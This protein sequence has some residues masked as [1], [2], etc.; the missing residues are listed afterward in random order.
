MNSFI[1]KS[2]NSPSINFMFIIF[3]K[4]RNIYIFLIF[5]SIIFLYQLSSAQNQEII[6]EVEKYLNQIKTAK[7]QFKQIGPEK[8]M[9]R[10][11]FFYIAKPGKLKW[12]Y[13][14]PKKIT[15]ISD[16]NKV[17][18]YDHEMEELT[19]IDQDHT[20]AKLL[21]TQNVSLK[22][23]VN[24]ISIIEK[25][26]SLEVITSKKEKEVDQYPYLVLNF[27]RKPTLAIDKII[28]VNDKITLTE[29]S[30]ADLDINTP[31]AESEFK[32]KNPSFFA[33]RDN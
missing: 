29:I 2:N 30:L 19:K 23:M 16:N 15:V 7:A 1:R 5:L 32:F 21:T 20:L 9:E 10:I 12:E 24:I 22:K 3:N 8:G 25:K 18:Y 13:L 4:L 11:G 17:S 6:K 28:V 33:P 31:I 27:K 14:N 26:N